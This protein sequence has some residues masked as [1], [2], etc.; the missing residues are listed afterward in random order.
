MFCQIYD[1]QIY[2]KRILYNNQQCQTL[3]ISL[4]KSSIFFWNILTAGAAPKCSLIYQ[5]LP[6]WEENVEL[7]YLEVA[8]ISMRYVTDIN[9]LKYV[10]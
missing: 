7:W 3:G 6:N 1:I 8:F 2:T 10:I 9:F 5:Y 4:N